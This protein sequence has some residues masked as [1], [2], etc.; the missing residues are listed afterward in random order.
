MSG[1]IIE[2]NGNFDQ[3]LSISLE[4]AK[5]EWKVKIVK[6]TKSAELSNYNGSSPI[7]VVPAYIDDYPVT[8][9]GVI[10]SDPEAIEEVV[11]PPT[12][13]T[14]TD[15]T[16]RKCSNL[17]KLTISE[18]TEI[19]FGAFEKCD[20][21]GDENG[22]IVFGGIL[23]YL[24]TTGAV[25]ISEGVKEIPDDFA[26]NGNSKN[27]KIKSISFPESLT[28]IGKKTFCGHKKL[29]K[30]VFPRNLKIID[31]FAFSYN[32]GLKSITFNDGLEKLHGFWAVGADYGL[33]VTIPDSVTD[34]K[35]FMSSGIESI[36][37]PKNLKAIPGSC[38]K[39]CW[40]LKEINI[41]EGVESIGVMA[42]SDCSQL[43]K[44]YLPDSLKSIGSDAFKGCSKAR[45]IFNK[46]EM[47][48]PCDAF[49][50]CD[51]LKDLYGFQIFND[52][53][54]S[55]FGTSSTVEIPENIKR[56]GNCAFT[57]NTSVTNL[58]INNPGI[59]IGDDENVQ[60]FKGCTG[61][62]DD[63]GFVIVNNILFDYIGDNKDIDVPSNV[64]YIASKCFSTDRVSSVNI[65]STVKGIGNW[66]LDKDMI[67]SF[68]A[69]VPFMRNQWIYDSMPWGPIKD[70]YFM[71]GDC[72]VYCVRTDTILK[73][74]EGIRSIAYYALG[75]TAHEEVHLPEGIEYIGPNALG[76]TKAL[77][78]PRSI[79]KIESLPKEI[80]TVY[81]YDDMDIES[82]IV[83]K[84]DENFQV[85]KIETGNVKEDIPNYFETGKVKGG[86]LRIKAY[87]G[88]TGF[89]YDLIIPS[90]IDGKP[91][92]CIG[93]EAF[94][95]NNFAR[96]ELPDT[97]EIIEDRAFA[98]AIY[99]YI[100]LSANLKTLMTGALGSQW[101]SFIDLPETLETIKQS[102]ICALV[103]V[104]RGNPKLSYNQIHVLYANDSVDTSR[105][106]LREERHPLS[107]LDQKYNEYRNCGIVVRSDDGKIIKL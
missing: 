37:L 53:L 36:E 16:F 80:E 85:K 103:A 28:R 71:V 58:I 52:V 2:Y 97:V 13:E 81:I 9:I 48:F 17:S 86:G 44:V 19:P 64:E 10:S 61:L 8:K 45:F 99:E 5:R 12:V 56:I 105:L 96:I 75:Y 100:K 24:T 22:C 23:Y 18:R 4:E 67:I 78:L 89:D 33:N 30:L 93:K 72:L 50:D 51:S 35:A 3:V 63:N 102:A 41:P 88:P 79:K 1:K 90:H 104:V 60:T 68:E 20:S 54:I 73:L 84:A 91:V 82:I 21:L 38:F 11:I 39:W 70:G 77:Y 57:D 46:H 14:L 74:P 106:Y 26:N 55:Y 69:S 49:I 15:K 59:I 47:N 31:D 95:D 40:S 62:A 66:A 42:F 76:E 107:E 94:R 98:G 32:N 6:K 43:N 7:I 65:P 29:S 83:D 34:F 27:G 101:L 92:T 87:Y 25:V